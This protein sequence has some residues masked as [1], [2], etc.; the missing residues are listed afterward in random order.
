MLLA[1]LRPLVDVS[2]TMLV[3]GFLLLVGSI[4]FVSVPIAGMIGGTL[5]LAG[6]IAAARQAKGGK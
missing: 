5:L 1:K 3:S 2:T 4:A 6:G